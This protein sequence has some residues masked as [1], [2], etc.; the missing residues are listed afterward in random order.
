MSYA[1]HLSER[2]FAPLGMRETSYCPDEPSGRHQARGLSARPEGQPPDPLHMQ[3]PFA[4][5]ALCSTVGDLVRWSEALHGHR[6]LSAA[7]YELMTKP[8]TL[9][10][11]TTYPYGFG[12]GSTTRLLCRPSPTAEAPTGS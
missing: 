11:G 7:F 3:Y 5:G 4:A 8:T 1:D 10:S 2:I 6:F 9:A 12:L